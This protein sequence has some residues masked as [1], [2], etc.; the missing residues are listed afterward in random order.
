MVKIPNFSN[1]EFININLVL[2]SNYKYK[3]SNNI[4]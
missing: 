4:N 2:Y 1:Y 3:F